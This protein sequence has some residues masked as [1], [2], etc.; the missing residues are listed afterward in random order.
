[1]T[2]KILAW[3][4][5]RK[6]VDEVKYNTDTTQMYKENEWY[7][8]KILE[9]VKHRASQIDHWTQACM[10]KGKWKSTLLGT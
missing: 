5:V 3:V 6:K 4:A 8:V 7:P 1:M 2:L 10:G 9:L